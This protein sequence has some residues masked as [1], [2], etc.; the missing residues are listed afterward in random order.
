MEDGPK[1]GVIMEEGYGNG[2]GRSKG[3]AVPHKIISNNN[4]HLFSPYAKT[5]SILN[6]ITYSFVLKDILYCAV[7][8]K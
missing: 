5:D 4:H 2:E 6:F 8:R 7:P 3:Y 1:N